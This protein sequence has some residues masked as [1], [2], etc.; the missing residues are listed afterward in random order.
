MPAVLFEHEVPCERGDLFIVEGIAGDLESQ[1]DL[2]V[3]VALVPDEVLD[4]EERVVKVKLHVLAGEDE[5]L[6][7]VAD[8]FAASFE[9][10]GDHVGVGFAG[11]LLRR[12]L[13]A[14]LRSTFSEK[15][16]AHAVYVYEHLRDGRTAGHSSGFEPAGRQSAQQIEDDLV[17]AIPGIE[18]DFE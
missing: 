12:H 10:R 1:L 2:T 13:S 3:V 14:E 17:V 7:G 15:D 5:T 18:N 16:Q 9:F 11:P 4:E 6:D 8:G